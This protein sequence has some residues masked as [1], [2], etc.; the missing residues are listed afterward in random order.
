MTFP[1][2]VPIVPSAR[3]PFPSRRTLMVCYMPSSASSFT[4]RGYDLAEKPSIIQHF[5]MN[6]TKSATKRTDVRFAELT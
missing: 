6:G 1:P 4:W 3:W 5:A 2:L